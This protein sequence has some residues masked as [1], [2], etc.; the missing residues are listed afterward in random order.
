MS[1]E[2]L[3][4]YDVSVWFGAFA[5]AGTPKEIVDRLA[6]SLMAAASDPE[7]KQT[8]AKQGFVVRL[9][10]PI[11]FDKFVRSEVDRWEKVVQRAGVKL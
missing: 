8:L 5:P 11:E 10:N 1:E 7:I 4:G 3:S 6:T 2:G 9:L